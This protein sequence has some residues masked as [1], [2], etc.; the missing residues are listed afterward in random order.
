MHHNPYF[1][2]T[3]GK[4]S[5]GDFHTLAT[6]TAIDIAPQAPPNATAACVL[7]DDSLLVATP[8]GIYSINSALSAAVRV[9]SVPV[10]ARLEMVSAIQQVPNAQDETF[11][12]TDHGSNNI[13]LWDKTTASMTVV[14]GSSD[15][16]L[17][18]E[19][20]QPTIV[21]RNNGDLL[22]WNLDDAEHAAGM[23][24]LS[25]TGLAPRD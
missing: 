21:L 19:D 13:R 15:G 20:G 10:S 3:D 18:L 6:V 9:L 5:V 7:H 1:I 17:G 25:N 8:S 4:R 2:T 16:E 11:V 24:L 12:L 23:L 14:A 22:L